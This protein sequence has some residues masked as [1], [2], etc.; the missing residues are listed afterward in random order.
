MNPCWDV[1]GE[2]REKK[3]FGGNKD[4][5]EDNLSG[6]SLQEEDEGGDQWFFL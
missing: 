4:T 6:Y 1:G 2:V 5:E 3:A